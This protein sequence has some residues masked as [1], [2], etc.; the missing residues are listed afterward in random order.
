[1][2]DDTPNAITDPEI[3]DDAGEAV[4]VPDLN[5]DKPLTLAEI[6]ALNAAKGRGKPKPE[7][8]DDE[9]GTDEGEDEGDQKRAE[10]KPRPKKPGS[11]PKPDAD[12]DEDAEDHG[13][14]LRAIGKAPKP[15][16]KDADGKPKAEGQGKGKDGPK[17]SGETP[18]PKPRDI[19]KTPE[20]RSKYVAASRHLMKDGYTR[21][22]IDALPVATVLRLGETAQ[23]RHTEFFQNQNELQRLKALEARLQRDG[24]EQRPAPN[25]RRGTAEDADP[26]DE[27]LNTDD[28]EGRGEQRRAPEARPKAP[29]ASRPSDEVIAARQELVRVVFDAANSSLTRR[30]PQLADRAV[31]DRV[32]RECGRLDPTGQIGLRGTKDEIDQLYR[33][34]VLTVLGEPDPTKARS[35]RRRENTELLDGQPHNVQRRSDT[36]PRDLSEDEIDEIS[37]RVSKDLAGKSAAEVRAEVQRRITAARRTGV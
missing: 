18:A 3:D 36:P 32:D 9:S 14:Y 33:D 11:G 16:G 12:S 22:E 7:R 25:P 5:T 27:V 19:G 2:V 26:L 23:K 30:Y 34:A 37:Y 29:E 21:A 17:P 10:Q 28:D 31:R 4:E 13:R 6:E 35:E 24:R 15:D 20:E 8:T 1:M